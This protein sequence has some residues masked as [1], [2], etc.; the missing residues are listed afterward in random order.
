MPA[1]CQRHREELSVLSPCYPMRRFRYLLIQPRSPRLVVSES[2]DYHTK[3]A[4]LRLQV[5]LTMSPLQL[6]YPRTEK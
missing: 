6:A 2:F 5:L 1:S 3:N 4:I